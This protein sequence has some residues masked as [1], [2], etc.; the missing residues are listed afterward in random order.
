MVTDCRYRRW[1]ME[2]RYTAI[3][4]AIGTAQ[5]RDMVIIAG[6]GAEDFMEVGGWGGGV[7]KVSSSRLYVQ[8]SKAA[9]K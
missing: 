4:W 5:K 8:P 6:K 3:R 9:N 2:D 7:M 1:V